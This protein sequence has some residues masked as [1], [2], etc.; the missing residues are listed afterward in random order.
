MR[1]LLSFVIGI[2][3][4]GVAAAQ[5]MPFHSAPHAGLTIQVA[6]GCDFRVYRGPYG[7]C[8]PIY[9]DYYRSNE[10]S[11]RQGY[12]HGYNRGYSDGYYDGAG[13]SLLVNQGACSGG[14]MYRICYGDGVCWASCY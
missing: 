7:G 10:R 4:V 6:N 3:L 13:R 12:R 9:S 11:Y 5:A 2:S 1:K 14:D 8:E